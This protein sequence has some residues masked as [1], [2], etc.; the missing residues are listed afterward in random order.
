MTLLLTSQVM[1]GQI[2]LKVYLWKEICWQVMQFGKFCNG[3]MTFLLQAVIYFFSQTVLIGP[4]WN[5][6]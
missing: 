4:I 3:D 2:L 1:E 6:C 5:S